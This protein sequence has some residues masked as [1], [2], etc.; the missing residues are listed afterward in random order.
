MPDEKVILPETI[1]IDN[2]ASFKEQL[3]S[4]LAKDSPVSLDGSQVGAIDYSGV[5]LLLVYA[6]ELQSRGHELIWNGM[7]E[8]LKT[9]FSDLDAGSH[10]GI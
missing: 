8:P 1:K 3:E 2:V 10:L 4:S 6:R 7:S 5:Q 9:A